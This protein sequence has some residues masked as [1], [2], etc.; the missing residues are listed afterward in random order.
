MTVQCAVWFGQKVDFGNKELESNFLPSQEKEMVSL[1]LV[2]IFILML[3][4]LRV[5]VN[6]PLH[7]ILYSHVNQ[8]KIRSR[9]T[10]LK[11]CKI[12]VLAYFENLCYIRGIFSTGYHSLET[13]TKKTFLAAE[14]IW[15]P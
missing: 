3:F 7:V 4:S 11:M 6:A 15:I 12:Y 8:P 5:E 2:Y 9:K 14:N 10:S 1:D 13:D